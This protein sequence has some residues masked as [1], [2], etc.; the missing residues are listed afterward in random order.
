MRIRLVY[1]AMTA[2]MISVQKME[3]NKDDLLSQITTSL[4]SAE[5]T[6]PQVSHKLSKLVNNKFQTEYTVE[7]QKEI[8]QKYKVSINC[9]ELFVPKV[10]S[11]IWTKLNADSKRSDI[12]T[13]VLQDT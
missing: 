7:K 8:L 1:W 9:N 10:N 11:E 2:I 13:S 3:V 5:D 12:R 6:G 4:S